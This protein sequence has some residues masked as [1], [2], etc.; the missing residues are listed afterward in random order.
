MKKLLIIFLMLFS[1]LFNNYYCQNDSI[2]KQC[3]PKHFKHSVC[4]N[5]GFFPLLNISGH[6]EYKFWSSKRQTFNATTRINAGFLYLPYVNPTIGFFAGEG[7]TNIE[8]TGGILVLD[9][10]DIIVWPSGSLGFRFQK[11]EKPFIF[12]F[13]VGVPEMIY[14]SLG[15]GFGQK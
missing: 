7:V 6:Y 11:R 10:E 1:Q 2:N 4:F 13:G 3:F 5:F 15:F 9:G 14:V 12:R 8:L